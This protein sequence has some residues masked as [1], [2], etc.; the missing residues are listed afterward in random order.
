MKT[1]KLILSYPYSK[2]T[3]LMD[4]TPW[5]SYKNEDLDIAIRYENNKINTIISLEF[6]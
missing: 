4:V 6:N 2:L 3:A 1:I 5:M